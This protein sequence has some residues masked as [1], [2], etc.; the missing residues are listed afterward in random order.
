M[1]E[2]E[3]H[4]QH[5]FAAELQFRLA[6]AVRLAVTGN[7]QPLD[8]P[9]EWTHGQQRIRYE[10]I[11]LRQDQA[12]CAAFLLH[13]SSTFTMA[14]AI[15]DAIEALVPKLPKVVKAAKKGVDQAIRGAIQ[16]VTPKP[17][18]VSDDAVATGYHV[19]RLIRNAYSHAP[20][21]PTWMIHP[22]LQNQVF[23]IP[24]VIEFRTTG[25]HKTAFDWRHYGGP[26]ALF[27]L[28]R[29]VR[30][31]VLN[32]PAEPRKVVPIPAR[33]IYQQGDL[34]LEEVD[35]IPPDVILIENSRLDGG[36]DLGGGHI[37]YP[38]SKV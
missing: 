7:R 32:D 27:R 22:E 37:V 15:K 9:M 3:S 4:I 17:W 26:L 2:R 35:E 24:N 12:A 38:A 20:F 36:V 31:E 25:L 28:C 11:A 33:R 16:A 8:L 29:F 23:H 6:S 34:I 18:K 1:S 19:A 21:A 13:R 14:V 10:E 5:L 30:T